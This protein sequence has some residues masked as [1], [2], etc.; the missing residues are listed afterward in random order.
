MSYGP[1]D[2]ADY[3]RG[4]D[5]ERAAERSRRSMRDCGE[6][7]PYCSECGS[8]NFSDDNMKCLGCGQE[9]EGE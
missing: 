1:S 4:R 6:P 8:D 5:V 2:R 3:L 7:W 9:F